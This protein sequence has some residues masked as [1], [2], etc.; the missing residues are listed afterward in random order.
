MAK[1]AR[2]TRKTDP[3]RE[4]RKAAQRE[5]VRRVAELSAEERQAL[6]D[7]FGAI[8]NCEGRALSVFNSALI[9]SQLESASMVGGFRQWQ[10]KGRQVRKGEHGLVI[11]I[12]IARDAEPTDASD[13]DE[14]R[15]RFIL[16]PV[17]DI[18]QTEEI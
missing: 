7:K 5:L 8:P 2:K 3:A 1:K 6:V 16:R 14:D 12:P 18:S 10:D 15:K 9:L 13:E 17:F 4:A 11:W